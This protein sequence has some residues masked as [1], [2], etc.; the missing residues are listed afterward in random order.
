[1]LLLGQLSARHDQYANMLQSILPHLEFSYAAN[2][3]ENEVTNATR[4]KTSGR[5]QQK[6]IDPPFQLSNQSQG[7]PAGTRRIPEGYI[8]PI[9]IPH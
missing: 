9:A 3:G 5:T 1:M 7:T 8:V 2:V 4:K 6:V